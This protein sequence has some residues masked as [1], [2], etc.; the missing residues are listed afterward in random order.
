MS[1]KPSDVAGPIILWVNY[2]VEGWQPKSFRSII[3]A[4]MSERYTSEFVITASI[5]LVENQG[6]PS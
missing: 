4:L 3:E 1:D 5:D 6:E 2:G